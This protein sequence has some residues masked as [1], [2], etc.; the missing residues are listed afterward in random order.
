MA[1]AIALPASTLLGWRATRVAN[2][3]RAGGTLRH[4]RWWG[5]KEATEEKGGNFLLKREGNARRSGEAVA[6]YA[7]EEVKVGKKILRR[8][9]EGGYILC[10]LANRTIALITES[11]RVRQARGS[12]TP[13]L[14]LCFYWL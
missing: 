9:W 2:A 5:G 11:Q 1:E 12:P 14:I 13:P 3:A 10:L 6:T 8:S 4:D 7:L